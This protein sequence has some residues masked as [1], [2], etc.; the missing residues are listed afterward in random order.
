MNEKHAGG[1]LYIPTDPKDIK[2]IH[3][4]IVDISNNKFKME[5]YSAHIKDTKKRLK[6]DYDLPMSVINILVK[7][8]H[9]KAAQTYFDEQSE[10]EALYDNVFDKD[11]ETV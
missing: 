4:S 9:D 2:D 7:L 6:E 11:G 1:V 3:D 10:V 8:Y 5:S